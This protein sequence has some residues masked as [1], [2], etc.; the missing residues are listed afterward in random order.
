MPTSLMDGPYAVNIMERGN[1]FHHIFEAVHYCHTYMQYT[2]YYYTLHTY[3]GID[4]VRV[5]IYYTLGCFR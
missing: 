4:Y 1:E 5:G 3:F 2:H